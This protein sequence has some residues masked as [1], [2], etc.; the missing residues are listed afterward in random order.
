VW[1]RKSAATAAHPWYLSIPTRRIE[2]ENKENGEVVT[3]ISSTSAW[4]LAISTAEH[5]YDTLLTDGCD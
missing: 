5:H 2:R 4:S 3:E 1:S